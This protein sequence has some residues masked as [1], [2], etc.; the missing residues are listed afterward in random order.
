MDKLAA[1]Q[2]NKCVRRF[3]HDL[4]TACERRRAG[5][6]DDKLLGDIEADD[7]ATAERLA[8]ERWPGT[9]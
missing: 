9:R 5:R 3:D 6:S 4:K 8:R 1:E 2:K 7:D